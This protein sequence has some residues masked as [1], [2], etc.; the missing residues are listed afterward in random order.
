VRFSILVNA[1]SELVVVVEV[2]ADV[3]V[4]DCVVLVDVA[5]SSNP[6]VAV[7]DPPPQAAASNAAKARSS[8]AWF[9]I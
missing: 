9:L 7:V 5:D 4:S 2:G 1:P 8:I 6:S 3:V